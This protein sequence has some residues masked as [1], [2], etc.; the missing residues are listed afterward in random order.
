VSSYFETP[1]LHV[2]IV[3]CGG[4]GGCGKP[5]RSIQICLSF[6]RNGSHP[7]YPPSFTFSFPTRRRWLW[8]WGMR[9]R[10]WLWRLICTGHDSKYTTCKLIAINMDHAI[11]SLAKKRI[12]VLWTSI[13]SSRTSLMSRAPPSSAKHTIACA[14]N[15]NLP[16]GSKLLPAKE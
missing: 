6:V 14:A 15:R 8:R 12:Q 11:S 9:R 2:S 1:T 4:G 3:G 13:I 16:M 7:T 5:G 10:W